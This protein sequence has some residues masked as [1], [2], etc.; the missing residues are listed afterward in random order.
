[1]TQPGSQVTHGRHAVNGRSSTRLSEAI[2]Q[3]RKRRSLT[4][5]KLSR[6]VR[7]AA[8]LKD[9]EPNCRVTVKTIY[10]WEHGDTPTPSHRRSLA[11]ALDWPL[12]RLSA[13]VHVDDHLSVDDGRLCLEDEADMERREFLTWLAAGSAGLLDL[14]RLATSPTDAAWL[15][16]AEAVS[17]AIAAQRSTVAPSTLVPAILGHLSALE[18]RLPTSAE[19]TASTALLTGSLLIKAGWLAQAYRCYSL[20]E[21]LGDNVVRAKARTGRASVHARQGDGE[22]AL[23]LQGEAVAT[24]DGAPPRA[25]AGVLARRAELR[26]ASGDDAGAMRDLDA[27]ERAI[28]QGAYEW[29][30]LSPEH[31]YE[32]G[33]YRGSALALLGRYREAVDSYEWTLGR[34]RPE[35]LDWRAKIV[36]DRDAALAALD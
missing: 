14:E 23:R 7:D 33:A 26:A 34:M 36:I 17:G 24:L 3:E 1:M 19:L 10:R 4:Q 2:V 9:G 18:A 25:Q 28:A 32:M 5:A 13:M 27:A 15:R 29:F 6:M 21:A 31:A 20:A 30:Y 35:L 16:D 8:R 11:F 12:E 22:R